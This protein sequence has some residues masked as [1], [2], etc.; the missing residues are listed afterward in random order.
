LGIEYY[1][2]ILRDSGKGKR[3][4]N[5]KGNRTGF[6]LGTSSDQPLLKDQGVFSSPI[7]LFP[8][9]YLLVAELSIKLDRREIVLTDVE[10]D[11]R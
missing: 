11:Q 5:K 3:S 4:R 9:L 7:V 1:Y 6:S 8:N 2:R 10:T